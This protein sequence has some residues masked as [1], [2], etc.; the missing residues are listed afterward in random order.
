[1]T[2]TDGWPTPLGNAAY[3][4]PLGEYVRAIEEHSEA[5]PAA[6]LV[7]ALA[8]F[9]NA[10]GRKPHFLIE[11]T[12]H[13]TN[14]AA[15]IVGDTALARKGTSF[16][17][18]FAPVAAAD[19]W[20]GDQNNSDGGL[21]S[22][23]GLIY[24]VRDKHGKD[25]GVTDKRLLAV[26]GEFAE[27][28]VKMNR[29]NSALSTTI[30]NAWDGRTLAVRTRRNPLKATGAHVSIIGHITLADLTRSLSVTD[31]NNGFANRFVWVLAR[32]ARTLPF[33]GS[34]N[35][36]DLPE[37]TTAVSAA[38]QWA[39]ERERRIDFDAKTT[40][41][42]PQL[43]EE[44]MWTD[45][46]GLGALLDRGAPQVRRLALVY[47]VADRSSCVTPTHIRAAVEVW[48]YSHE[49]VEHI[50]L[51]EEAAAADAVEE[52]V[53]DV[54]AQHSRQWIPLTVFSQAAAKQRIQAYRVR[55]VL[56]QRV[57][58]GQLERQDV[59]TKGRP[60]TEYRSRVGSLG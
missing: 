25:R 15:L 43:Y 30:R 59:R 6:I 19:P 11:D 8:C 49:S 7:Q 60:R 2:A 57:K 18:A 36:R 54:L 41:L 39:H 56:D 13:G 29:E 35:I 31:I 53:D 23:E 22:A 37:T 44:L 16:D 14:L 34:L 1:M 28:L 4:G 42:W 32:R 40:R 46:D 50:W 20:W 47:A 10:A 17:R 52:A 12:R 27:T 3:H 55:A 24:A 5:D 33:G 26:M 45:T 58:D 51:G 38:L 48:R 9:G 21:A